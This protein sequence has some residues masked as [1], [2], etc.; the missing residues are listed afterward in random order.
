MNI[1]IC[2]D[3][4]YLGSQIEGMVEQAFSGKT[5]DYECEVFSSGDELL[6]HLREHPL[7][8]QLYL[9]DIEMAGTNG[10]ETAAFIRENDS[11]AVIIFMTSHAELMS[12]AFRVMAFQFVVKPFDEEKTIGILVSAIQYIQKR[13]SIYQYIVRK[14]THTVSLAQIAYIESMGRKVALHLTDGQIQEYYGTMKEA[15]EKTQGIL[16]VQIHNSF[17]INLEQLSTVESNTVLL[18]NGESLPIGN[19]FHASFHAAFRKFVLAQARS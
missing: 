9:L 8:F 14:K 5:N 6:A 3:N 12:E 19:K 17:L 13:K 16:F 15:V 1:A 11:D 18:N 7:A 2:D 10:L 4:V